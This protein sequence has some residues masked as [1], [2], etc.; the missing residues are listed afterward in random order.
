MSATKSGPPVHRCTR[1]EN[2]F[3]SRWGSK[4]TDIPRRG[5]THDPEKALYRLEHARHAAEGERRGAEAHD[6]AIVRA[7]EPSNKLNRVRGRIWVIEPCIE[8]IK[9][10][11][12]IGASR[13]ANPKD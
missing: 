12:E 10:R 4:V 3:R 6:F 11:L 9:S 7:L 1:S 2:A 8:T 5:V 13:F